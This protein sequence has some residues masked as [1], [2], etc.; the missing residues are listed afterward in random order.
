MI[1]FEN[2][3]ADMF[4]ALWKECFDASEIGDCEGQEPLIIDNRFGFL[5]ADFGGFSTIVYSR[6]IYNTKAW[7]QEPVSKFKDFADGSQRVQGSS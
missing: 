4:S 6:S 3:A 1:H 5:N 2:P 7:I